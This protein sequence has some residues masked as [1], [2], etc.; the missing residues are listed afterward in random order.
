L[1]PFFRDAEALVTTRVSVLRVA[2]T[3]RLRRRREHD[4]A[5]PRTRLHAEPV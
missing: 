1:R 5:G 2:A 4:F 3:R